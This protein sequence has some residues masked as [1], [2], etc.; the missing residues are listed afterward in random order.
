MVPWPWLILT[1]M[2]LIGSN[3][4]LELAIVGES[5]AM[6]LAVNPAFI[7]RNHLVEAAI[8]AATERQN[9]RPFEQLLEVVTNPFAD[10]PDSEDYAL[11]ARPEELVLETFCGT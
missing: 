4:C 1:L 11:P 9:F 2:A 10:Q 5:A 8:V 6:M 3:G 7:P